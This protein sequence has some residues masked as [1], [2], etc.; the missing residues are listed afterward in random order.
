MSTKKNDV[1]KDFE[2]LKADV[3]KLRSDLSSTTTKLIELGKDESGAA[4][5][6]AQ[7]EAAKLLDELE[8][9]IEESKNKGSRA[10]ESVE[11]RITEKPLLSLLIAF[12]LGLFLGK[13]IDTNNK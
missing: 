3:A 10:L 4:K 1:S 8:G 7:L 11:D 5:E 12:I 2:V 6:K 9:A 13:I